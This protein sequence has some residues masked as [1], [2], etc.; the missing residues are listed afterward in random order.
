LW[1]VSGTLRWSWD[2]GPLDA[3]L[4]VDGPAG[5]D[6]ILQ[7]AGGW[8]IPGAPRTITISGTLGGEHIAATI[9]AT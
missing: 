3:D 9:P 4:Q 2:G 1:F 7:L 8:L 5:L 6:G